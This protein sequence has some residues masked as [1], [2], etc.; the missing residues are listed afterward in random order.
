MNKKSIIILQF[1]VFLF[2]AIIYLVLQNNDLFV[3]Y[4]FPI[5]NLFVVL[6]MIFYYIKTTGTFINY[7][8]L[9]VLSLYL[10]SMSRQITYLLGK[11][12][13]M[14]IYGDF[15]V[16]E[17]GMCYFY[18]L[19]CLEAF[20][21]GTISLKRKIRSEVNADK[22]DDAKMFH[23][24]EIVLF[25]C[26][27]P[28]L[29]Y[30]YKLITVSLEFKY[31][32][33][34]F[35]AAVA[36]TGYLISL[37]R[38]WGVQSLICINVIRARKKIKA[39]IVYLVI[40]VGIVGLS[41]MSGSRTEGLGMLLILVLMY[42][43]ENSNKKKGGFIK[44][45]IGL[46]AIAIL[47]P[48]FFSIRKDITAISELDIS[49]FIKMDSIISAAHELGGSEAPTLIAMK[50]N[51]PLEL[52][53]SY[54]RAMLNSIVN[55][56]PSSVRPDLSFMGPISLA[57]YYS[58][59]LGLNYGLGFSLIAESYIN[60]AYGG[61]IV[62][63]LFGKLYRNQIEKDNTVKNE[64]CNTLLIFILFT[65][66]RRESK[67]LITL[68]V[69]YWLPF[70]VLIKGSFSRIQKKEIERINNPLE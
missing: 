11:S 3:K 53:L 49:S 56:L 62:F 16:T 14:S 41:L 27:I 64:L 24:F 55:F 51:N 25:V 22:F 44:S 63:Y 50:A 10:F 7:Y 21:V 52:G 48:T 39:P 33:R 15:S 35:D 38:Q 42:N 5:M 6:L 54:I 18:S 12:S 61:F 67:D 4:I 9:L 31:G 40:Y 66:T 30:Y 1:F 29:W 43:L 65:I 8:S 57:F 28:M 68:L 34:E 19:L 46:F 60:F 70:V 23:F 59:W 45:I 26:A 37:L 32:S 58:R 2:V 17:Y 47:I 13:Y 20:F 36:G 69:Y